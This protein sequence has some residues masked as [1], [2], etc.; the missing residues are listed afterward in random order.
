MARESGEQIGQSSSGRFHPLESSEGLG[1]QS[2]L[3]LGKSGREGLSSPQQEEFTPTSTRK[4]TAGTSL[5]CVS[6]INHRAETT[7]AQLI[8]F[9]KDSA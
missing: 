2:A 6:E 3:H 4:G 8:T 7:W 1:C 5:G 9:G